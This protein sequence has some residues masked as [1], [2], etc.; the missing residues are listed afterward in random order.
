MKK[1]IVISIMIVIIV[2]AYALSAKPKEE[3]VNLK[4]NESDNITHNE[5]VEGTD[6]EIPHEIKEQIVSYFSKERENQK[7]ELIIEDS[8]LSYCAEVH[9]KEMI[10]NNYFTLESLDGRSVHQQ[11]L[12]LGVTDYQIFPFIY[13]ADDITDLIKQVKNDENMKNSLKNKD[14][15][16]LGLSAKI[17]KKIFITLYIVERY[18]S[19]EYIGAIRKIGAANMIIEGITFNAS[20]IN[21][22]NYDNCIHAESSAY[23]INNNKMPNIHNRDAAIRRQSTILNKCNSLGGGV[24]LNHYIDDWKKNKYLVIIAFVTYRKGVILKEKIIANFIWQRPCLYPGLDDIRNA[25]R[26]LEE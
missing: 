14:L 11:L 4:Q 25:N 10:E 12:E 9:N 7:L 23:L 1:K 19:F 15:N 6:S 18:I 20:H 24:M 21:Y 17:E 26:A 5:A 13:K 8:L 22:D 3:D 16:Y 2:F